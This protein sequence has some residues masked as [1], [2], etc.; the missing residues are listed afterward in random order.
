L[1]FVRLLIGI[2]VIPVGWRYRTTCSYRDLVCDVHTG[3]GFA[4]H[5]TRECGLVDTY[6]LCNCPLGQ[7]VRA[8]IDV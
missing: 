3:R 5:I 4:G 1:P 2:Y 7:I 8:Y 6:T